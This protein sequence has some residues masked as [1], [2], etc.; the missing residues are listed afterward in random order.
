MGG[1]PCSMVRCC[2][3]A[4]RERRLTEPCATARHNAAIGG[5]EYGIHLDLVHSLEVEEVSTLLIPAE[6]ASQLRQ[7]KVLS[8]LLPA[9]LEVLCRA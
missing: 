3:E 8:V 2:A 5:L 4:D 7:D 6:L 9:C 1:S